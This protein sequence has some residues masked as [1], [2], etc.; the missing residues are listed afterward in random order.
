[1][2]PIGSN[3]RPFQP[4]PSEPRTQPS[5]PSSFSLI[6]CY[7][8]ANLSERSVRFETGYVKEQQN[9]HRRAIWD[10]MMMLREEGVATQH[11]PKMY[12]AETKKYV[13]DPGFIVKYKGLCNID[14]TG[15]RAE[16][17]QKERQK[18]QTSFARRSGARAAPHLRANDQR[19]H[20]QE[21]R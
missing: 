1:M 3:K 20:P 11:D 15:A 12:D 21:L 16:T 10:Q 7:V 18:A 5:T 9:P 2:P 6:Q 17:R 19:P 14:R 4:S 8:H 13:S